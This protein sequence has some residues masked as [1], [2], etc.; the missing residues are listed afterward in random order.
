MLL[1]ILA[2]ALLIVLLWS[3]FLL[4]MGLRFTKLAREAARQAEREQGRRVVAELP[5]TEQVVL[6]LED[7]AGFVWGGQ[8]AGKEEIAGARVLLNGGVIGAW[9]LRGA[10]PEPPLAE[11]Y[12]GRE[13]WEVELYLRD[14]RR[15][16]VPCGTLRE[17]VSR[18]AALAVFEAVKSGAAVA[19][20]DQ[21]AVTGVKP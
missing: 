2:A 9:A 3:L 7:D 13:R 6:F 20:A 8:R 12:E 1:Q 17:G 16:Q 11:V 14:G 15:L 5:V 19:S 4:A 10:L 18:E 21:A